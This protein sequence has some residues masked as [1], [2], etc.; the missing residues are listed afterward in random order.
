MKSTEC[1]PIKK[2]YKQRRNSVKHTQPYTVKVRSIL[3]TYEA[4]KWIESYESY[5]LWIESDESDTVKRGRLT[6]RADGALLTFY[7]FQVTTRLEPT[8]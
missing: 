1:T 2:P 7:P 8:Y 3:R 5:S 6:H 4:A